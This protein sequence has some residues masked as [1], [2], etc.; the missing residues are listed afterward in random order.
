LIEY[1]IILLA[2]PFGL[3]SGLLPSIGST[4]SIVLLYVFLQQ[5]TPDII[6][7]FYIV[8]LTA[9]QFS[10]SVSA[11]WLGVM[12][13]LTSLPIIRE[14]ALI[15][16]N[17][18]ALVTALYRTAQ[19]SLMA[20]L[21]SLTLMILLIKF[22]NMTTWTL[23]T[24]FTVLLLGSVLLG[25]LFWKNSLGINV[26]LIGTGAALSLIGYNEIT[27]S[28]LINIPMLL[29]GIPH[30]PLLIGLY[31][32]P[33]LLTAHHHFEPTG[34]RY[35]VLDFDD[36]G[37]SRWI[38]I[39]SGLRG[40]AI[41]MF[42]GLIPWLGTVISS[43]TAHFLENKIHPQQTI[44]HSLKRCTAA[45]AS[46]NAAF[47]SMLFPLLIFG[48]AIQP[49][50]AIVLGILWDKNW[51]V[52]SVTD[53]TYLT[54]FLSM[55]IGCVL[56][57]IACTKF[58][59]IMSQSIYNHRRLALA[60]PIVLVIASM[61]YLGHTQG[62]TYLYLCTL[63]LATGAGII[64]HKKVIDVLPL[65]TGFLIFPSLQSAIVRLGQLYF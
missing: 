60:I 1:L 2:V 49:H 44:E 6:L 33:L 7:S 13:E 21:L 43:N 37:A 15:V 48:I 63:V 50:E 20:G 65:I 46:N 54:M 5:L 56:S 24:E 34:T 26:V 17:P 52:S 53:I 29:S 8:F 30:E 58:S 38:D 22:G 25:A 27:H 28:T 19:T 14:R 31:A 36:P 39:G 4:V 42:A 45:E 18:Q 10:G 40:T 3:I 51:T 9:S 62:L 47:V 55:I 64:I 41:G 11:L 61:F 23:R 32:L 12:G 57:Y 35:K 16:S 59:Q